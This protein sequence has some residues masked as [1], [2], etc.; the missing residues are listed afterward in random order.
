MFV[1]VCTRRNPNQGI[2]KIFFWNVPIANISD[3]TAHS[4]VRHVEAPILGG[5]G[6]S[7]VWRGERRERERD[8]VFVHDQKLQSR[9]VFVSEIYVRMQTRPV[10][11][12][13]KSTYHCNMRAYPTAQCVADPVRI[14][15]W[16]GWIGGCVSILTQL[17]YENLDTEGPVCPS[18]EF[19]FDSTNMGMD[20]RSQSNQ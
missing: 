3:V 15:L 13:C 6:G 4:T 14:F 7:H 18:I 11:Q 16:G 17:Q 5:G 20:F 12:Q 19:E 9:Q 1:H 10:H 2:E 8:A